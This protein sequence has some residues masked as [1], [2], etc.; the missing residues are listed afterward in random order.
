MTHE[1][2]YGFTTKDGHLFAWE[3][4]KRDG[5]WYRHEYRATVQAHWI[6]NELQPPQGTSQP[7]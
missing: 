4:V 5:R 3:L 1:P 7:E 6:N 2:L